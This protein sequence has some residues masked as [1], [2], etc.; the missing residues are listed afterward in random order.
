MTEPNSPFVVTAEK[1]NEYPLLLSATLFKNY[2]STTQEQTDNLPKI[3]AMRDAIRAINSIVPSYATR[4]KLEVEPKFAISDSGDIY[5]HHARML[6]QDSNTSDWS[7]LATFNKVVV[8]SLHD[9]PVVILTA[10]T[11]FNNAKPSNKVL[12][13]N[14]IE[15]LII[16][17]LQDHKFDTDNSNGLV[18][19]SVSSDA[20]KQYIYS[21]RLTQNTDQFF[22][23]DIQSAPNENN[24]LIECQR[25]Y[26]EIEKDSD[27]VVNHELIGQP[28]FNNKKN[29]VVIVYSYD[30]SGMQVEVE[31]V[32]QIDLDYVHKSDEDDTHTLQSEINSK[33]SVTKLYQHFQVEYNTDTL[34]YIVVDN[35]PTDL[36]NL[37][38]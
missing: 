37:R 19:D 3:R 15:N 16:Q 21:H 17:K 22:D 34:R 12:N 14:E 18:I 10:P 30:K 26:T 13:Q 24:T 1:S 4:V 6:K 35:T 7:E 27:N 31:P 9:Q 23:N 29:P 2:G 38:K 32:D 11:F 25:Y 36:S 5:L 8:T 33:H 20:N 28:L